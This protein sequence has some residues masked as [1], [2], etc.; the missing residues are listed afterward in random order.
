ML[1]QRF[2]P[3][4]MRF[5]LSIFLIYFLLLYTN[6]FDCMV[7]TEDFARLN[8][9]LNVQPHDTTKTEWLKQGEGPVLSLAT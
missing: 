9:L 4:G 3:Q 1:V 5:Q 2:E 7:E 8:L 6:S